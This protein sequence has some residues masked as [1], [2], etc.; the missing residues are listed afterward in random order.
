MELIVH[1]ENC[2]LGG[3]WLPF[4]SLT[5][6]VL[7]L[8][9]ETVSQLDALSRD[10]GE[11][12]LLKLSELGVAP[13]RD[14][15]VPDAYAVFDELIAFRVYM[16][17]WL[18]RLLPGSSAEKTVSSLAQT[19]SQ[20]DSQLRREDRLR[21]TTLPLEI[22]SRHEFV[23]INEGGKEDICAEKIVFDSLRELL[24]YDTLRA[25]ELGRAP[26]SCAC[27][28]TWFV[29]SR[30]NEIF[31][32]GVAENGRP[33]RDFGAQQRFKQRSSSELRPIFDAACS[34]IYTRKS[35]KKIS[36]EESRKLLVAVREQYDSARA[37]SMSR[38]DFE[39]RLA[40]I[41]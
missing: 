7:N 25:A 32:A 29:P 36:S 14:C 22:S 19:V 40:E 35:R 23:C 15:P 33:C 10:S 3:K 31:C 20:L 8:S 6:A 41:V 27:C 13:V 12:A 17:R 28:S 24:L 9:K 37:S 38:E 18:S 39:K 21:R 26:R 16:R 34:R 11:R 4:G 5:A 2:L 30:R 1:G